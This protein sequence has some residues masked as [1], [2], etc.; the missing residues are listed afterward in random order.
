MNTTA[1][2][3]LAPALPPFA[4]GQVNALADELIYDTAMGGT[5]YAGERNPI[6][7]YVVGGVKTAR[8]DSRYDALNEHG[9][10]GLR[11]KLIQMSALAQS[12]RAT[13][14]YWIDDDDLSLWIDLGTWVPSYDEAMDLGARRGEKAV[15]SIT[16]DKVLPVRA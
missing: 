10:E 8:W 5:I 2:K 12:P 9:T 1:R 16:D 13:L 14:G 11:N 3:N 15:Y 6:H 7:G 4:P